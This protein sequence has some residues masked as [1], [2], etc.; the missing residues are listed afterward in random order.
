MK[1]RY[2][3]YI[4]NF[5]IFRYIDVFCSSLLWSMVH[6]IFIRNI[7]YYRQITTNSMSACH[8]YRT[9]FFWVRLHWHCADLLEVNEIVYGLVLSYA[10]LVLSVHRCDNLTCPDVSPTGAGTGIAIE[11]LRPQD[12]KQAYTDILHGGVDRVQHPALLWD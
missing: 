11:G 1:L 7:K 12:T 10:A 6:L 2:F 4:Q 5:A 9:I 3:R 8:I